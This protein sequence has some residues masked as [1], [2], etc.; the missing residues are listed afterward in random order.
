MPSCGAISYPLTKPC[1]HA[2]RKFP[3]KKEAFE[4]NWPKIGK[5]LL[6]LKV[7]ITVRYIN[8]LHIQFQGLVYPNL[9]H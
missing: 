5:K 1:K 4:D 3:L 7:I 8:Q 2:F 9:R 6:E